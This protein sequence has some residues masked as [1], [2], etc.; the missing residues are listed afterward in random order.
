MQEEQPKEKEEEDDKADFVFFYSD[1][2]VTEDIKS[3]DQIKDC[4]DE[5]L[6]LDAEYNQL[7]ISLKE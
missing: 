5:A 2:L 7:K 3:A 1:P 6:A 4:G